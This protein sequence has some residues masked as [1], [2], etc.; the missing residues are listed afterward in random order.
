M[1][2]Q[3][4]KE[5]VRC[6]VCGHEGGSGAHPFAELNVTIKYV[7][8]SR[9]GSSTAQAAGH[10]RARARARDRTDSAVAAAAAACRHT[11]PCA[12]TTAAPGLV[13]GMRGWVGGWVGG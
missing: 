9:Q 8:H 10:A 4:T 3:T 13:G 5:Y 12:G 11:L 6:K 2:T 7:D 1:R